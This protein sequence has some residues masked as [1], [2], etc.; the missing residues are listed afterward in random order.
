MRFSVDK[1]DA[2]YANYRLHAGADWTIRVD[3][4]EVEQVVTADTDEGL[5]VAQVLD[6]SGRPIVAPNG[7]EIMRREIR[8]RVSVRICYGDEWAAYYGVGD[9]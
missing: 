2:G 6:E 4:Q 3:G 8:G 5:V 7:R 9:G 1:H